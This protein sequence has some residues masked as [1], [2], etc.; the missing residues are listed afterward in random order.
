MAGGTKHFTQ[1]GKSTNSRELL[2]C[3]VQI[4]RGD[5]QHTP[6]NVEN[7]VT[8]GIGRSCLKL[9]RESIDCCILQCI[10]SAPSCLTI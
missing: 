6:W 2:E 4:K 1:K 5:S 3:S 7:G 10:N 9:V 8:Q